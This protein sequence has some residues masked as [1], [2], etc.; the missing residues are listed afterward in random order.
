MSITIKISTKLLLISLLLFLPA[1]AQQLS[2][3]T[4]K[5]DHLLPGKTLL[6]NSITCFL[7]DRQG[8]MWIGTKSG[9]FR[10]DGYEFKLFKMEPQN[11]NSL[12]DNF[13]WCLIE[14]LQD[15]LLLIGT[16]N[17]GL[18]IYDKRTGKF[19]RFLHDEKNANSIGANGVRD[20]IED[21][22]G[23]IW[24]ATIGGGLNLFDFEHK[25]FKK[26]LIDVID[27]SSFS[28]NFI[29]CLYLD[30][31]NNLWVGTC[32]GGLY[33]FDRNDKIFNCFSKVDDKKTGLTPNNIWS[34]TEDH[35][36]NLWVSTQAN[37]I[38]LQKKDKNNNYTVTKLGKTNGLGDHPVIKTYCDSKGNIWAGTWA[39]G[40]HKYNNKTN[41]FTQYVNDNENPLS[42]SGNH[43]LTI[44][45]DNAGS[46]WIGTHSAGINIVQPKKWKFNP[47]QSV[48]I[49]ENI[50]HVNNVRAIYYQ[51]QTAIL[52]LG[53]TQGLIKV[54]T[55]KGKNENYYHIS[56][57]DQ[58]INHN[59][60]NTICQGKDLYSLWIGTPAGLNFMNTKT[61]K[62]YRIKAGSSGLSDH[63]VNS[64]IRD[65]EGIL[66][67]GTTFG[68]LNRFDPI[69]RTCKSYRMYAND[70]SEP[71]SGDIGHI[72]EDKDG[73]LYLAS[74]NGIYIFDKQSEKFT[75]FSEKFEN[76]TLLKT[77][78]TDIY[79]DSSGVFWIGTLDFGLLRCD[80]QT[81]KINIFTK[82]D[83]LASNYICGI[84][85]DQSG[86][87]YISTGH[88]ISRFDP[89]IEKFINYGTEDGLHGTEF[90][91]N[92]YFKTE[93]GTMYFGGYNGYTSFIPDEMLKNNFVPP[94]HITE[95]NFLYAQENPIKNVLY[96][97]SIELNYKMNSFS[98]K[99]VAL[100]YINSQKNNFL[101]KLEGYD[102]DWQETNGVHEVVYRNVEPGNYTFR[103]IGSN[104]DGI[105]NE[106]GDT[107]SI[108]I[109]PPFWKTL[110]F[111]LFIFCSIAGL[112][113]LVIKR[114]FALL[115]REAEI[116]QQF[117]HNLITNQ[118]LERK[119]IAAEL[120]DSLGQDLLVIKNQ[121][122]LVLKQKQKNK[123]KQ[124]EQIGSIADE[125]IDH[126]RQIS[127]N[128]HPYQLEKIGLTDALKSM[129]EKISEASNI[130]FEYDI[131]D[132]N[133]LLPKENE[134][135]CYRI[136]QELMNNILKHSKAKKT[137]IK[138]SRLKTVISVNVRDNGIGFDYEKIINE[139][140]GFG[141]SGVRERIEILKGK[142]K[143]KSGMNEGANFVIE[144]PIYS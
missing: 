42:I 108:F 11:D 28:R 10:Y 58:S 2:K 41:R 124:L 118:E 115:K 40:L 53:T 71:S 136:L 105:W 48:K 140:R 7:Q 54:D 121:T 12:S 141:L 129:V 125:A 74:S 122:S 103:V 51:E 137:W 47:H 38:F 102:R 123:I 94:V 45:E 114:R 106:E 16:N 111:K 112:I 4:I 35:T 139:K 113:Y 62:F 1:M 88:G 104:N 30:K 117:T 33:L 49:K 36:Y 116:R 24:L 132:I 60:I 126:I 73:K 26:Y 39:I 18:N 120:H 23:K 66:W 101:Y 130:K 70:S 65:E 5:F 25:I 131:D 81:G 8:F 107:L 68:G 78:I 32:F 99:F 57:D 61:D 134:I 89:E 100:N 144:I 79:Q 14:Y 34:I 59:A 97:S 20:I 56:G 6:E 29:R 133:N 127:Y 63:F 85:E 95:L 96:T 43:V 13:V 91:D 46:L 21:E 9:L 87:L 55:K 52:W 69:N 82:Q 83:G 143:I 109:K 72:F 80:E 64:I 119:R 138:I 44:F 128:L 22:K 110:G 135:N 92:A 27:S 93:D 17:G 98:I 84:I 37:G 19:S 142:L 15:E 76:D 90:K 75:M 3:N 67:I 31:S 86:F 50:L 77:H